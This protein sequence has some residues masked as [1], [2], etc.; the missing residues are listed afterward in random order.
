MTDTP[1][2]LIIGFSNVATTSGFTDG[3]RFGAD[4]PLTPTPAAMA[5]AN[6]STSAA[7]MP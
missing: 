1:R 7:F 4:T 6:A 3:G 2:L 5:R